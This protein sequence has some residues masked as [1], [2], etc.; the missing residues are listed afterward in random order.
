MKF[1]E[2]PYERVDVSQ[3]EKE[4]NGLIEALDKAQSGEEQFAIHKRY[5][6]FFDKV[7]TMI[8]ISYI[9]ADMLSAPQ[10]SEYDYKEEWAHYG[11]QMP[12][13][14][15]MRIKYKEKIC[16]SPYRY[17]LK[18]KI[19]DDLD[20]GDL[21]KVENEKMIQLQQ[22][23]NDLLRGDETAADSD[24]F[25][26]FY[27]RLVKNR[28]AQAKALGCEDYYEMRYFGLHDF[29]K[30]DVEAFRRQVKKYLVPFA[31]KLHDRGKKSPEIEEDEYIF[32]SEVDDLEGSDKREKALQ[33]MFRE[34]APKAGEFFDFMLDNELLC[35]GSYSLGVSSA[36]YLPLYHVPVVVVNDPTMY[37]YIHELG[38]AFQMYLSGHFSDSAAAEIN[39]Q[40]MEFFS[41][42]WAELIY[43]A[44]QEGIDSHLKSSIFNIIECC[45][46]GEF[47]QIVYEN[48]DMSPADRSKALWK[49]EKEYRPYLDEDYLESV[50]LASW[51]QYATD[52]EESD[53]LSHTC[54]E[55]SDGSTRSQ[56]CLSWL[57]TSDKVKKVNTNVRPDVDDSMYLSHGIS[58]EKRAFLCTNPVYQF[59]YSLS[60]IC[61][62]QYKV[63]MEEDFDAAWKSYLKLCES[64]GSMSFT[65]VIK[66]AGLMSPFEDGCVK[67][68]VEKLEK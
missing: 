12:M 5:T 59:D 35:R 14:T 7:D 38:H 32:C 1:S 49:L 68:L 6:D 63:M 8:R 19:G 67:K 26:E 66:E 9:R 57:M 25:D 53:E 48:P 65:K 16:N 40:S 24:E 39:S 55:T 13:Y 23:E 44:G 15:D 61:A 60:M 10:S 28:A 52:D 31:E 33:K 37:T 29:C 51:K 47:E 36:I 41:E 58:P 22:E 3:V 20:F 21:Q 45:V 4:V 2:M 27:D 42:K 62:L 34:M 56:E 11:Q 54:H 43:G 64:T 30:E 46:W 18:E 17:Y 50:L